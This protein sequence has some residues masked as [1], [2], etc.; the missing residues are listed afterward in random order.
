MSMK[1]QRRENLFCKQVIQSFKVSHSYLLVQLVHRV[2][3][4]R[5]VQLDRLGLLVQVG[6][7]KEKRRET[8]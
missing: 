6:Y 5:L 1:D 8:N 7:R 4:V 3:L 2:H